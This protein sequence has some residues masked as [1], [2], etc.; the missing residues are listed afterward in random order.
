MSNSH[1]SPKYLPLTVGGTLQRVTVASIV[2]AEN[3]SQYS[4]VFG[5]GENPVTIWPN[6]TPPDGTPIE[7]EHF[8]YPAVMGVVYTYSILGVFFSLICLTF[9]FVFRKKKS[10]ILVDMLLY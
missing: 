3:K 4:I 10:A 2:P 7:V 9:N 5:G 6:G 8:P 1:Y